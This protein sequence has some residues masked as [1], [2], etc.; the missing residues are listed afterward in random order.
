MHYLYAN[1]SNLFERNWNQG[2]LV[3]FANCVPCI[4]KYKKGGLNVR[5]DGPFISIV[6]KRTEQITVDIRKVPGTVQ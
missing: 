1:A 4:Q 5:F 2:R 6:T 3:H